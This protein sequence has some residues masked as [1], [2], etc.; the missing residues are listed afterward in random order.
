MEH[1]IKDEQDFEDHLHYI[2]YNAAK[3]G[4]VTYPHA[5]PYSSFEKWIALGGGI[6]AEMGVRVRRRDMAAARLDSHRGVR[7]GVRRFRWA[8]PTLRTTN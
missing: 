6:H 7:G 2:H 4:Y 1:T 8:V 3:H 5:W